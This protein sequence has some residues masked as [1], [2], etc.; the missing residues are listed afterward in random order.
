MSDDVMEIRPK[1]DSDQCAYDL[2]YSN[3]ALARPRVQ[4]MHQ[5]VCNAYR[6][7]QLDAQNHAPRNSAYRREDYDEAF[8]RRAPIADERAAL[9]LKLQTASG[10]IWDSR[11]FQNGGPRVSVARKKWYDLGCVIDEARAALAIN[12]QT[13]ER[14]CGNG[15]CGW[16]GKTY[17]MCGS[18]GPLCPECGETTEASA[19]VADREEERLDVQWEPLYAAPQDSDAMIAPKQEG[20][21]K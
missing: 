10:V 18:V 8:E 17:R 2:G 21:E 11:S 12:P 1:V 20:K 3:P 5:V 9:L 14:E 15:D 13:D 6:C 7:G 4:F 19:P 16:R